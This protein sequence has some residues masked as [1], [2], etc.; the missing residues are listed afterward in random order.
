[1]GIIMALSTLLQFVA[2]Y[3]S[4]R[5]ISITGKRRAWM[6]IAFAIAIGAFRR[7][8]ELYSVIFG[9][10]G[11][12]PDVTSELFSLGTSICMLAGVGFI[13]P[14][15]KSVKRSKESLLKEKNLSAAI[16]NSLPGIF[17]LFDD[18]GRFMRWNDNLEKITGYS[19]QEIATTSPT[20][21][22][23]SFYKEVTSR[24]IQEVFSIGSANVEANLLT[25][26]GLEIPYYLSGIRFNMD[27]KQCVLGTGIDISSQKRA[28]DAISRAHTE[29]YQIFNIAADAM[30]VLDT[31]FNQTKVNKTFLELLSIPENE[32]MGKKCYEMF[33]CP[34]HNTSQCLSVR[35]VSGESRIEEE[36][37]IQ[38]PDGKQIECILTATP[39]YGPTGDFIGIIEDFRDMTERKK[40]EAALRTSEERYR[41][42]FQESKDVIFISTPEGKVIDINPA[43]LELFGY[44]SKEE[45]LSIDLEKNLYCD[46]RDRVKYQN[47]L[48][49]NE[50]V[51]NYELEMKKKDGKVV[52]VLVTATVL[53]N[54]EGNVLVY[55]GI[56]RD[57]TEYKR[58]E[59]QL[60]Q[61]QKM[62]VVG[63][64]AGGISHDFNNILCAIS[65]Y[66]SLI[67]MKMNKD[68]PLKAYVNQILESVDRAAELTHGL[69]A[70]SRRQIMH[71][72]PVDIKKITRKFAKLVSRI[73]GENIVV[74]AM[75]DSQDVNGI[76]DP[77]QIEQV[78]MN[79][80]INARD[81]MPRGGLLTLS[82]GLVELDDSFIHSHGYG[83][84]GKY[85]L[86]TVSD[87]GLGMEQE[88][89][90]RIFEPFF[91]TKEMGKGTGLGL[92]IVYG[93]IK[94]H[95]G[96]INVYSEPGIGTTFRI[97]LPA[98][99]V[100]E[101]VL[102][103]H[104]DEALPIGGT[105]TVLVAEDDDKLRN[106]SNIVLT[107]GGYNVIL[108]KD[109]EEAI[110]KFI[111]KK[112]TI[113]LV[114]LDIIMPKKSGK[115]AFD[116]I[117]K[118]KP[119]MKIIFSSGYTADKIDR[120]MM[121]KD[122]VNL[123]T[124]PVS[125]WN[126]LREVRAILDE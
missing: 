101:T 18:K 22:F 82:A 89:M 14:L 107:E 83:K 57:I 5:M 84:P 27:G 31:E 114:I 53:K 104:I 12:S 97:Y 93:I 1:M 61:A 42:L 108:A 17:F 100:K 66:G 76:A 19:A 52:T 85:A 119:D 118:I 10:I 16:I 54:E 90:A 98:A 55:R 3:L 81:A 51:K 8:N 21:F 37:T 40:A 115:E 43:G 86:I 7:T 25:K 91:T 95:D 99:D 77:G 46:A 6:L 106:L 110:K 122:K 29:L 20:D 36:I 72:R 75:F 94:Q 71:A 120:D 123:I 64:L 56:M 30:R 11:K 35:I 63:Q 111:D 49:R 125:P 33:H 62:E 23:S 32:A 50:F 102:D 65:G 9:N 13:E 78:L 60:L 79:L 73:I 88:E 48:E 121:L 80:T 34:R 69:L 24:K 124:K 41:S 116:E 67:Q 74:S 47:E 112:D 4:I 15:F 28:E 109:G 26:E 96:Y 103:K 45:L 87:T 126:L 2:A 105:E 39:H 59:K 68:D 113:Q 92:A 58:L 44:S 38:R 70:F 117:I